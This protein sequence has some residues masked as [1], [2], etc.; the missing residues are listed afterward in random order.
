MK[1]ITISS[2]GYYGWGNHTP[3]LI[4][5]LDWAEESRAFI[6]L[7][8]VGARIFIKLKTKFIIY[9]SALPLFGSGY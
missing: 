2:W 6:P 9:P 5:A 3:Y 4:K 7:I 1:P 8:F